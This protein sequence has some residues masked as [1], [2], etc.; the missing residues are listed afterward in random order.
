[1]H[2][3]FYKLQSHPRDG[4]MFIPCKA[5]Q[6][7]HTPEVQT[8]LGGRQVTLSCPEQLRNHRVGEE[9]RL[10]HPDQCWIV[11]EGVGSPKG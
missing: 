4:S 10:A 1:M 11:G 5:L 7:P 9:V 8:V 6:S 3:S 2:A